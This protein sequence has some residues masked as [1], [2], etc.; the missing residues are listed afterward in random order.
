MKRNIHDTKKGISGTPGGI[1]DLGHLIAVLRPHFG[2]A[3]TGQPPLST[4]ATGMRQA[5]RPAQT[6]VVPLVGGGASWTFDT[7]FNV[8]P[9]IQV[10]AEGAPAAG[11]LLYFTFIQSGFFYIGVLVFSTNAADVRPVHITAT[12]NPN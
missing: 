7:P 5:N 4:T 12:G 8:K 2:P 9:S 3:S 1:D 10:S 11:A 6:H